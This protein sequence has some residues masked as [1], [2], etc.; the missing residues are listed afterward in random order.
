MK[1][2]PALPERVRSM[3]GLGRTPP[4]ALSEFADKYVK[5]LIDL[6]QFFRAHSG[7]LEIS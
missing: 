3:E 5:N 1:A 6:V 4:A 7:T 2:K